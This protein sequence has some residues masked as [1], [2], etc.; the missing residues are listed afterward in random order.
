YAQMPDLQASVLREVAKAA[1]RLRELD[2][3]R[4]AEVG[5][6]SRTD[7]HRSHLEGDHLP[8]T[9]LEP[10]DLLVWHRD[11][12]TV[13]A[14]AKLG[15]D[16]AVASHCTMGY[17][18]DTYNTV[19]SEKPDIAAIFADRAA[20]QR[21]L[22]QAVREAVLRHKRLGEPVF[23]WRDGRVGEIPPEEISEDE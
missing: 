1:L 23:I 20:V 4:F 7:V 18:V 2:L 15:N 22:S 19:R 10:L 5:G 3:V 11:D 13:P 6:E 9:K 21:A 8:L 17:T 14:L 12:E 16:H